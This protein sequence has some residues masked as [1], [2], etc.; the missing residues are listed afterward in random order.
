M[1]KHSYSQIKLGIIGGGQLARMLALDAAPLGIEVHILSEK[2]T[3]PAAMVTHFWHEG[4]P[5]S[6]KDQL[7]FCQK[8]D[9][10]TFESEFYKMDS[11]I[12]NQD[13]IKCQIFPN[14][15]IMQMIQHRFTQKK[16]LQ[17]Y[18]LKTA[19]FLHVKNQD[20]LS[21]AAVFF[22]NSFVLKKS[23]GGYDG[24]GTYYCRNK[25]DLKKLSS[26]LPGDFIAE[27]L[28]HFKK[29]LAVIFARSSNGTF[30]H[31][32]LVET[33]QAT[34]RCDWVKGPLSHHKFHQLVAGLKKIM[35]EKN[36]VGVLGVEIFDTG[37]DLYINELAPRVHNSGH[38]S[39]NAL[40]QSQFTLH[41]LA[42]LGKKL[43]EPKLFAKGFAMANLIGQGS[44][45]IIF[46][47][48]LE[49]HLHWYGKT[50]NRKGRKLG[51]INTL[52]PTKELAL[53]KVLKQRKGFTL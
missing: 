32:P 13:K 10:L 34:S 27:E 17:K 2:P 29:E 46:P 38:Y 21:Q 26:L 19:N 45:K 3:D 39:Q 12:Q 44:E 47:E 1:N 51:H 28:I 4:L 22:Q 48:N 9:Y 53:K 52:A 36:Y 31:L 8:V 25:E 7:E 24:Y 35:K 6:E 40:S 50:D 33:H 5:H 14:P 18:K 42:G 30:T 43:N 15:G 41:I 16:L 20:D 23:I 49:T 11:L 37:K